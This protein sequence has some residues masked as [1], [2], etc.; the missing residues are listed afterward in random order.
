VAAFLLQRLETMRASG[1]LG[2]LIRFGISGAISSVIYTAVYLP[3]ADHVLPKGLAV[4]AVPPAFAVA[5]VCGFFMH[6]KWSFKDHGTRDPSGKQHAKFVLVQG[7]GLG[8]N[9]LI[10]WVLTGLL[11]T[12]NW[13]PLI[14]VVTVIPLVTFWI[15]RQWVF[16]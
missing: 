14:P 15:N 13:V 2:Q 12:A 16:G 10:T 4:L 5:V 7:V 8:L 3:L 11:L 1:M 9:L 6:S